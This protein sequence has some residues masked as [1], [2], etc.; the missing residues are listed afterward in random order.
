MATF[1]RPATLEWDGDVTSGSG[2]VTAASAAFA[3]PATFPSTLGEPAGTTTPEELLAASHATCYGV[4]LRSLIG[5]RGGWARRVTVT[6][7]IT[8]EKGPQGIRIQSSHLATVIEALEGID[9][10]QLQELAREVEEGCAISV[11]LRGTVAITSE[12]TI[13]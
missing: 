5:R 4:G 2:R 6:A 13:E 7:I 12:V 11:A 9:Q 8:A 3:V 10:A 1:S